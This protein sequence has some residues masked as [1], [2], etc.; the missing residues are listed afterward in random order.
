MDITIIEKGGFLSYSG[1]GLPG[2]I[3]GKINSPRALMVTG[4]SSVR[5]IDFFETIDN[6]RIL[7][8]TLATDID[9]K[10]QHVEVKDLGTG[11]RSVVPYDVLVI[12]TGAGP[13]IPP[14][15]GITASR[16]SLSHRVSVSS[17]GPSR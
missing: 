1:C 2:Y 4:D 10:N 7:N 6:I 16:F 14:I 17:Y 3:S 5:D 15:P 12:A 8:H 13:S 9:S 11:R